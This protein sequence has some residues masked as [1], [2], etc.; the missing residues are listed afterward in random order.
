MCIDWQVTCFIRHK[1]LCVVLDGCYEQTAGY[2]CLLVVRLYS[3]TC[4]LCLLIVYFYRPMFANHTCLPCLLVV[5]FYSR[6]CL[7]CLLIVRVYRPVFASRIFLRSIA[8][9][10]NRMNTP[11]FMSLVH[12]SIISV[13]IPSHLLPRENSRDERSHT[14]RKTSA[15]ICRWLPESRP[16]FVMRW[17]VQLNDGC[18][19]GCA[20]KGEWLECVIT[21][22]VTGCYFTTW[23]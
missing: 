16:C 1:W 11:L 5:Y 7:P 3:R 6:T 19:C 22:G 23:Y 12:G 9:T 8:W 4:L 2:A 20:G 15:L 14:T 13:I 10:F 21:R 18:V 17:P